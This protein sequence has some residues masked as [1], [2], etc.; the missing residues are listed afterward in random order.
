M[1]KYINKIEAEI[2]LKSKLNEEM[3]SKIKK[4]KEYN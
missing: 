2:A 3:S 4:L 1:N